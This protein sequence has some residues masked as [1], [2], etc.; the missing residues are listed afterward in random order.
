MRKYNR[1]D[2]GQATLML[3]MM[4]LT[5]LFFFQFVVST[6]LLINAKINLQNA[7]DMAA[8]AGAAT[9][10]RQ[11]NDIGVLNYEMRRYYKKFLF[12]YYAVGGFAQASF[13]PGK[14][15]QNGMRRWMPDPD[16]F[17][18][19]DYRVPVVCVIYNHKDN[20]CQVPLVKKI[21]ELKN[22][23]SI[24]AIQNALAN[25]L[26]SFE[27]VRQAQ[28][29]SIG[30]LNRD[31]LGYW[32]FK[33]DPGDERIQQA[34]D[35]AQLGQN[36]GKYGADNL[37]KTF[38]TIKRLSTGLG[39]VPKTLLLHSR[40][41]TLEKY[42]N[43][44]PE[45][46]EINLEFVNDL[47]ERD[48]AAKYERTIQAFLSAYNTLG[49]HVFS[50]DGIVMNELLPEGKDGTEL[51]SLEDILINFEAYYLAYTKE[52]EAVPIT[53]VDGK[54]RTDCKGFPFP[55]P[56]RNLPI[57]VYKNPNILTYYA[58]R[59]K[60]PAHIL[61]SPFGSITLKAYSAAKP[62]GSRLGP[63]FPE[64]ALQ[65]KQNMFVIPEMKAVTGNGSVISNCGGN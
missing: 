18:N 32:L 17:G 47:K 13:P 14:E 4:V 11:L 8:Y 48:E 45:K 35:R 49:E 12:R 63:R 31:L 15:G 6:G 42:V 9:Q 60:A 41:K 38:D 3:A 51:L 44:R 25:Q 40:I 57:G 64:L 65:D 52:G 28:C 39:L 43:S 53:G 10:A 23:S 24:N 20:Y 55:I 26:D 58:I 50:S 19:V 33:S 36:F 54:S 46:E 59:L 62:F 34:I 30:N 2:R 29:A 37:R 1:Q 16:K 22:V 7:A 61:F 56:I 5:F 21:P 27:E